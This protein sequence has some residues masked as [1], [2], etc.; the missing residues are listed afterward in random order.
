LGCKK[1]LKFFESFL[2]PK[3]DNDKE[4]SEKAKVTIK[5][6]YGNKSVEVEAEKDD[7]WCDLIRRA[8]KTGKLGERPAQFFHIHDES[9][10]VWLEMNYLV[11]LTP[12]TVRLTIWH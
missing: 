6:L 8:F 10:D 7:L 12:K 9:R 4:G 11:L 1:D 5:V 3:S 2:R